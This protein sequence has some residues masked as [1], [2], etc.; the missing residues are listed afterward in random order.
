MDSAFNYVKD[1]GIT[2]ESEYP[3]T[4]RDGNTCK[5]NSGSFKCSGYVDITNCNTLSS[6]LGTQ[7]ISVAVDAG[8]WALYSGGIFN[9]C[10]TALNH[11]VLLVGMGS[12]NW[13]VKNSWGTG[14]G[15]NGFIR[16]APG[17]TCG[18]CSMASYAKA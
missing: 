5:I 16:L 6:A 1:H 13:W 9:N 17:N 2:S 12:D 10:G 18:I 7:A 3:Y 8:R 15:E 11:G 4:A 14:W